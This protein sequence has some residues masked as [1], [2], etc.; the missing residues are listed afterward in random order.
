MESPKN[1]LAERVQSSFTQLSRAANNLNKVSGELGQAIYTIDSLL[2]RLNLGV[3]TWVK[4]HGGEDQQTGMDYWSRDVGYA[5]V[6][7]KWG[8]ALRTI[9]GNHNF[10]DDERCEEWLFGDAPRSMR[11]EGV[12]KIPELLEA[13]I[14][15]TEQTTEKIKGKI[16]HAKQLAVAI[17]QVSASGPPPAPPAPRVFPARNRK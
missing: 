17:A 8:I 16:D 10:P 11:V 4:I 15:N 12:E 14:K 1:S 9:E 13:L 6:G 2:Q 5:K 7:N 3:P